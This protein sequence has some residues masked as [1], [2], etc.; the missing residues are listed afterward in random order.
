M[1]QDRLLPVGGNGHAVLTIENASLIQRM[2]QYEGAFAV[3][4]DLSNTNA[5]STVSGEAR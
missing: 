1:A 2:G 3:R 5:G 4:L